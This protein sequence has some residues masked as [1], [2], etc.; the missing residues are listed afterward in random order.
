[1]TNK[2]KQDKRSLKTRKAI[3]LALF[4]M[5]KTTDLEAVSITALTK[6]AGV[7]RN[8]F[9]THYSSIT[10]IL[11]DINTDIL[12]QVD[13]M[14]NKYTYKSFREDAYPLISEFSKNLSENKFF[15]EY[16]LFSK[17]NSDLL[18]KLKDYITDRCVKQY[19]VESGQKSEIV[20]YMVAFLVGGV[21]DIYGLWFTSGRNVPIQTVTEKTAEFINRGIRTMRDLK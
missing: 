16:V 21:F 6:M 7:N 5:L 14:L 15:A 10:N 1:M 9:Y 12:F 4:K 19:E 20:P 11:D 18:R 8:S 3:K 13:E 17:N 2:F